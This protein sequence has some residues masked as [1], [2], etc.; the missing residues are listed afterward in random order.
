[1]CWFGIAALSDDARRLSRHGLAAI[2]S[3]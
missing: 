3:W 2:K 1:L